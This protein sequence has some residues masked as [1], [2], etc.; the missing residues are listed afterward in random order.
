MYIIYSDYSFHII[1][2]ILPLHVN[3]ATPTSPVP[4]FMM[5][6]F[7]SVTSLVYPMPSVKCLLWSCGSSVSTQVRASISPLPEG[8]SSKQL[9]TEKESSLSP[10]LVRVAISITSK[11]KLKR[12]RSIGLLIPHCC[13]SLEEVVTGNQ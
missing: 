3:P 6:V 10:A 9:T 7:C 1:S 13:L 8:I 11:S 12:K 2:Y 5:L 4:R